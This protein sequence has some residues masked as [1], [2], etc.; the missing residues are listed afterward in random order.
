MLNYTVPGNTL[1]ANGMLTMFHYQDMYFRIR[2]V[3]QI[4][5]LR[6]K[7]GGTII[8][9]DAIASISTRMQ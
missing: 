2:Q 6:L 5:R 7:F 3:L 9:S 4:S 8:L 1:G